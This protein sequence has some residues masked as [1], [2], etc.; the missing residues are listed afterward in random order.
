M[1]FHKRALQ[2]LM[3]LDHE[4]PRTVLAVINTWIKIWFKFIHLHLHVRAESG[5]YGPRYRQTGRS[6]I[7][8]F[9]FGK[10]IWGFM[11]KRVDD[12]SKYPWHKDLILFEDKYGFLWKRNP[13][14]ET[15]DMTNSYDYVSLLLV[16][17]QLKN[18]GC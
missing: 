11:V 15:R 8:S 9:G 5:E 10:L 2:N 6:S 16:M 17:N 12:L 18:F 7:K 13:R 1:E 3:K 14:T 4:Y